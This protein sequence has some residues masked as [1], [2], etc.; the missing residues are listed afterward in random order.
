ME[1]K[2]STEIWKLHI[3]QL[4]C[5]DWLLLPAHASAMLRCFDKEL[6]REEELTAAQ[7]VFAQL[8]Q[9]MDFWTEVLPTLNPMQQQRFKAA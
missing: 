6:G 8:V 7:L 1:S 2:S 3:T 5:T 9:P 4:V